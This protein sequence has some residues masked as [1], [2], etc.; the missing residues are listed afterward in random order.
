M[1][2]IEMSQLFHERPG[3]RVA[4]GSLHWLSPETGVLEV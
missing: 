4:F 2:W 1:P 3:E